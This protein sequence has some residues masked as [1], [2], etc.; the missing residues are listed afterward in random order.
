[1]YF[2]TTLTASRG[3]H[4]PKGGSSVLS[5]ENKENQKS[6]QAWHVFETGGV[7]RVFPSNTCPT[8]NASGMTSGGNPAR[9]RMKGGWSFMNH[10]TKKDVRPQKRRKVGA[11]PRGL[12]MNLLVGT[13]QAPEGVRIS[14]RGRSGMD[15]R[16]ST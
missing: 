6:A 5:P 2:R 7:T 9:K 4:V 11:I 13:R 8:Q 15:L 3:F 12:M 14:C 16:Q 10:P 1:M